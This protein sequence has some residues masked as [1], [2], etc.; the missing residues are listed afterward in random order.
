MT[1]R[2][3]EQIGMT[4]SLVSFAKATAQIDAALKGGADPNALVKTFHQD[5][6]ADQWNALK[7]YRWAYA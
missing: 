2:A 1:A 5:V 7:T 3:Y 4:F 6:L